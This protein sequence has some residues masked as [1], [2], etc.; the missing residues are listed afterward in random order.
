[1]FLLSYK[2][3]TSRGSGGVI[4]SVVLVGEKLVLVATI[5]LIVFVV[6]ILVLT[7]LL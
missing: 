7:V 6:V 4:S 2:V 5:L 3:L 1:M